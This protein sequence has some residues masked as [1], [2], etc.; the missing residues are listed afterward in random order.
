[1]MKKNLFSPQIPALI[2]A[3]E[4]L[5]VKRDE[6]RKLR[7]ELPALHEKLERS[8]QETTVEHEGDEPASSQEIP[9]DDAAVTELCQRVSSLKNDR[10]KRHLTTA[11]TSNNFYT[12]AINYDT[13]IP[14]LLD[15]CG[16]YCNR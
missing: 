11:R 2:E 9:A 14:S 3:Q 15:H 4:N 1:M 12:P 8:A 10:N 7:G 16:L 6:I 13:F 5:D